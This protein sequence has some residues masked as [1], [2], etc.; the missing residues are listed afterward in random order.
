MRELK[1]MEE[2]RG[3][4]LGSLG[5]KGGDFYFHPLTLCGEPI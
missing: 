1:N 4:R 2:G 3:F 5:K